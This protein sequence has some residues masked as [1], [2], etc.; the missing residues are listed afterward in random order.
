MAALAKT[1]FPPLCDPDNWIIQIAFCWNSPAPAFM[2]RPVCC[3]PEELGAAI[4]SFTA[5]VPL[6]T[7][8]RSSLWAKRLFTLEGRMTARVPERWLPQPVRR[9]SA[10]LWWQRSGPSGAPFPF[11]RGYPSSHYDLPSIWNRGR[12]TKEQ[13]DW[14]FFWFFIFFLLSHLLTSSLRKQC[15]FICLFSLWGAMWRRRRRRREGQICKL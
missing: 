13:L 4:S 8:W 11:L 6:T 5:A 15:L 3:H 1:C 12:R 7:V 2:R 9:A 10:N 14:F